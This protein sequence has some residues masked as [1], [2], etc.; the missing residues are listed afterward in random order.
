MPVDFGQLDRTMRGLTIGQARGMSERAKARTLEGLQEYEDQF[1]IDI[2]GTTGVGETTWDSRQIYF[3]VEFVDAT[4]QRETPY[5]RPHFTYGA[6]VEVG[7]PIGIVAMVS[8][9]TVER[10]NET[11][12]CVLAI[13]VLPTDE[14]RRF[15]GEVHARFQGYGAPAEAYGDVNQYDVD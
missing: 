15:R 3:N 2:S 4:A 7:S 10:R 1:K 5:D 13:G 8:R 6:Y 12:G 11:I 9:W 14:P